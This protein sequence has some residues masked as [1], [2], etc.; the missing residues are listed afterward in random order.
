MGDNKNIFGL[1]DYI[2]E[3][4]ALGLSDANIDK[5]WKLRDPNIV[6]NVSGQTFLKRAQSFMENPNIF[7]IYTLVELLFT[8]LWL[9]N[10]YPFPKDYVTKHPGALQVFVLIYFTISTLYFLFFKAKNNIVFSSPNPDPAAHNPGLWF[11]DGKFAGLAPKIYGTIIFIFSIILTLVLLFYFISKFDIA[12]YLITYTINIIIVIL[13][14]SAIYLIL[15]P[16]FKNLQ[17]SPKNI[18]SLIINF[19]LFIP[20]LAISVFEWFLRQESGKKLNGQPDPFYARYKLVWLVL[21][22][23]ALLIALRF[24]IPY[25]FN[26][27]VTHDGKHLL[28]HPVYLNQSHNLATYE[29]LNGKISASDNAPY[30]Y[31]YSLSAWIYINPQPPN[32]SPAY[33]SFT[34]LLNYN[35]KPS[36]EYNGKTNELRVTAEAS[37][38]KNVTVFSTQNI[39]YQKWN[40]FVINYDGANM[41]VFLNGELVGSQ[42]NIAPYMSLDDLIAGSNNGIHGGICNVI[43]YNRTLS[44]GDIALTYRTLRDRNTPIL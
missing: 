7:A 21:L 2:G 42:P 25:I 9:R 32:T 12:Y 15:K 22:V 1:G 19:I 39:I 13:A 6:P 34:P 35:G 26:K 36:I 43:Y 31:E 28:N 20:C 33:N 41:D 29:K 3:I 23:E 10:P 4:F 17:L 30:K 37:K 5:G 38:N 8:L 40:Y 16:F 27:I 44:K 24:I 18:F 14:I 11:S